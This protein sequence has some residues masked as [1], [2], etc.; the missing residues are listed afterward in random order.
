MRIGQLVADGEEHEVMC[1]DG[2]GTDV[3]Q[4]CGGLSVGCTVD[5]WA[6]E[7]LFAVFDVF[8]SAT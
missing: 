2:R 5:D 8:G 7:G 3:G 4:E 1:A 6:G